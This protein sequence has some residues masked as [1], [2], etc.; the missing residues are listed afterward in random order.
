M[1]ED[2]ENYHANRADQDLAQQP[3]P[4]ALVQIGSP[5]LDPAAGPL[6]VLGPQKESM[7]AIA[8]SVWKPAQ[9]TL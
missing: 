3:A 2:K 5:I 1:E 7:P 6:A 4:P 9:P 8:A